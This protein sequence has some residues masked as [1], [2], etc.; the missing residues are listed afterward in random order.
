M[1][2]EDKS[3]VSGVI[4]IELQLHAGFRGR[5]DFQKFLA[6]TGLENFL[7]KLSG[8]KLERTKQDLHRIFNSLVSLWEQNGMIEFKGYKS[9][10]RGQRGRRFKIYEPL[11]D[12][13]I[14]ITYDTMSND[15][16]E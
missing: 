12:L 5:F 4:A 9:Q 15:N 11:Y 14:K 2:D 3:S 16:N 8:K 1:D 13:E 7:E 6:L 10:E